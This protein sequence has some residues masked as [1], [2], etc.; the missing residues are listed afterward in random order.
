MVDAGWRM[1]IEFTTYK[2]EWA[3]KAVKRVDD[4][5]NSSQSLIGVW[6]DREEDIERKHPL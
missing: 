4:P 3:G 1:F 2:A 5:H 6:S